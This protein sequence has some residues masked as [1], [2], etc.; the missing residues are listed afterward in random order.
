VTEC[1]G[2]DCSCPGLVWGSELILA[3]KAADWWS[4]FRASYAD[5]DLI[6]MARVNV[7]GQVATALAG[8]NGGIMRKV[9]RDDLREDA[10]RLEHVRRQELAGPGYH[11]GYPECRNARAELAAHPEA[12][13]QADAVQ[14][15]LSCVAEGMALVAA[16]EAE[17]VLLELT[18]AAET[19]R[20]KQQAS[21]WQARHTMI[22]DGGH[23]RAHTLGAQRHRLGVQGVATSPSHAGARR[24]R[25]KGSQRVGQEACQGTSAEALTSRLR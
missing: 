14:A 9:I 18:A 8:P 23:A 2:G 21:Q 25:D 13:R 3:A 7:T 19:E 4:V 15:L 22:S 1:P 12:A 17:P 5:P 16:S 11:A 6:Q 24:G 10:G 20:A